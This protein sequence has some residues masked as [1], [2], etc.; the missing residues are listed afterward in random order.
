MGS[1]PDPVLPSGSPLGA[2]GGAGVFFEA[3]A[4]A[5]RDAAA[6]GRWSLAEEILAELRARRE[7][8]GAS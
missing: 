6:A 1:L 5:L 2:E 4:A 7:T 8:G 3:L